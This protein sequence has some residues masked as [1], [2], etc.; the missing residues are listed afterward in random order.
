MAKKRSSQTTSK[1]L[2]RNPLLQ[3]PAGLWEISKMH[4]LFQENKRFKSRIRVDQI[5]AH[6]NMLL[7]VLLSAEVLNGSKVADRGD[8]NEGNYPRYM[9]EIIDNCPISSR[10]EI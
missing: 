7:L 4:K 3:K 5:P 1:R 6:H 2:G 10:E 8:N 9:R